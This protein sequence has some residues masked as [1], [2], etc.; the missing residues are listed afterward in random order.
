MS[1]NVWGDDL[2]D[3]DLSLEVFRNPG[4]FTDLLRGTGDLGGDVRATLGRAAEAVRA[5]SFDRLDERQRAALFFVQH[6][7]LAEGADFY[8]VLG[9]RRG[10][11]A[12]EIR[13]H[14]H[15]LIRIVHPD[16]AGW[17]GI[18]C[19]ALAS[20]INIAHQ[21]LSDAAKRFTYDRQLSDAPVFAEPEIVVAPRTPHKAPA[22]KRQGLLA[23]LVGMLPHAVQRN[24]VQSVLGG[25]A[26]L[27]MAL[28]ASAYFSRPPAVA[29]TPLEQHASLKSADAEPPSGVAANTRPAES[30]GPAQAAPA[31]A[32]AP[33]ARP[34]LAA[35]GVPPRSDAAAVRTQ[36]QSEVAVV[37]EGNRPSVAMAAR[38][39]P[40][41]PV[42]SPGV[43]P[44]TGPGG[45][46][47][48]GGAEGTRGESAKDAPQGQGSVPE[49]GNAAA[50][51]VADVQ[52]VRT[53]E[54]RAAPEV[55]APLAGIQ[56]DEAR[57][58]A[59]R[60]ADAYRKGQ[61]E[62]FLALF[63]PDARSPS[64]GLAEIRNDYAALFRDSGARSIDLADFRWSFNG[65][66]AQG[67]CSYVVR[68]RKVGASTDEEYAGRLRLE[69]VKLNGEVR[70]RGLFHK[71]S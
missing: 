4:R 25:V 24:L 27:G 49:P 40:A 41:P 61:I 60:F 8:R 32:A 70:I 53:L 52:P 55:V 9:L 71:A 68:L 50:L 48:V 26:F 6:V 34:A 20:R 22:K 7:L 11:D 29:R 45:V 37:A 66:G 59:L 33:P 31:A 23:G 64:G 10:A 35:A 36:V 16:R 56:P 47:N 67:E 46:A 2:P 65:T 21:A 38:P 51:S 28:V 42:Q 5:G 39:D 57:A 3:S 54:T 30:A 43:R 58:L 13:D 69:L 19:E 1:A 63:A 12:E 18:D 62:G 15:L 14:Y 17:L 44:L